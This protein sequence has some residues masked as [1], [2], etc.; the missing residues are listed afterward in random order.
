MKKK[1]LL[2]LLLVLFFPISI[3]AEVMILKSGKVI[4]GPIVE[5][6]DKYWKINFNGILLTVPRGEFMVLDF[7]FE[8]EESRI[9]RE[10]R[11]NSTY[12]KTEEQYLHDADFHIIEGN[13]PKV[14]FNLTKAIE[15]NPNNAVAYDGRA[16]AYYFIKEYDKAWSDVHK[17]EALQFSVFPE[18]IDALKKASV[19]DK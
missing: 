8:D 18:F 15:I 2:I 16:F 1:G 12:P 7:E 10:K 17:A 4:R 19:R 3:F 14:V 9:A 6:T 11:L 13:Y 5:R